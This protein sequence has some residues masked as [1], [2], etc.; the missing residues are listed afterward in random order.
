ML[1]DHADETTGSALPRPM[2]RPCK[3]RDWYVEEDESKGDDE[4]EQ[5]RNQPA[6]VIAMENKASDPPPY[7]AGV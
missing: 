4:I 3:D 5:E 2:H 1:R 7:Q 6:Q